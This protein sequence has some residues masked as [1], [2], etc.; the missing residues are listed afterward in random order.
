MLLPKIKVIINNKV[1]W[2]LIKFT[3]YK[4]NWFLLL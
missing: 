1:G 3:I 4:S 2:K